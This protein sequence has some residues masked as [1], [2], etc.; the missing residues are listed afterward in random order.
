M[1]PVSNLGHCSGKRMNSIL[2]QWLQFLLSCYPSV[3]DAVC[4]G[5]WTCMAQWF[6][7]EVMV[8]ATL[9][10]PLFQ[11]LSALEGKLS[12]YDSPCSVICYRHLQVMC[13]FSLW[14]WVLSQQPSVDLWVWPE[15]LLTR[16][17]SCAVFESFRP[18]YPLQTGRVY[19]CSSM[20]VD[21]SIWL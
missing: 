9:K 10:L 16:V 13:I 15:G 20:S 5:M 17:S 21:C 8:T 19:S 6:C 4:W 11:T 14:N 1:P 2:C 12:C 7:S 3:F 18:W